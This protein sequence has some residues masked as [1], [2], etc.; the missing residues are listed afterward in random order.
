MVDDHGAPLA[1][2]CLVAGEGIGEL[3]LQGV[4]V[5]VL[6]HGTQ[7]VLFARHVGIVLHDGLEELL[8]LG[9]GERGGLAVEGFEEQF[10]VVGR[11]VGVVDK[12][13]GGIGK[14][15]TIEFLVV[16]EALHLGY[17]AVGNEAHAAFGLKPVVVVFHHHEVVAG[18][19]LLLAEED[20]VAYLLVEEVGPLVAAGDNN[21]LLDAVAAVLPVEDFL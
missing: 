8:R 21:H 18:V 17:V 14:M 16:A 11:E 15:E 19:H 1:A 9:G 7:P 12:A 3:D 6:F 5:G 2:L 20:A 4:V 13:Q 10:A